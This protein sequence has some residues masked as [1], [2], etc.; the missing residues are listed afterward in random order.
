MT[1]AGVRSFNLQGHDEVLVD[2]PIER[3]VYVPFS[4]VSSITGGGN[5]LNVRASEINQQ[6]WR[7]PEIPGET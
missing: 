2:R 3:D 6:N 7:A 5:N 4:A 1:S